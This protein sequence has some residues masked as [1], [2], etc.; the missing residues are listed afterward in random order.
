M[1]IFVFRTALNYRSRL[2]VLQ[3]FHTTKLFRDFL[4]LTPIFLY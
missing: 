3:I 2:K 1:L 4:K